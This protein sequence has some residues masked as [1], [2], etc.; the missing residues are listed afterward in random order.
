MAVKRLRGW[1]LGAKSLYQAWAFRK[2]V[3]AVASTGRTSST[4]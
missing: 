4:E 3:G 2:A 1:A